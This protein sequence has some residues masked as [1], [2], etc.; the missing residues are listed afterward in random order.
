MIICGVNLN[1]RKEFVMNRRK[2]LAAVGLGATAMSLGRSVIAGTG[3]PRLHVVKAEWKTIAEL[4]SSGRLGMVSGL[5]TSAKRP[6]VVLVTLSSGRSYWVTET[7][8]SIT[9]LCGNDKY[10]ES[11]SFVTWQKESTLAEIAALKMF[12]NSSDRY[13]EPAQYDN[14]I[15]ALEG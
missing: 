5:V 12:R 13:R 9:Q 10:D 14:A 15:A 3:T 2:F 11:I 6:A 7:K 8:D 4:T 1:E